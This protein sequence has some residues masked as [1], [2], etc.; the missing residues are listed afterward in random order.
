MTIAARKLTASSITSRVDWMSSDP[1]PARA[2]SGDLLLVGVVV[3]STTA[4]S[5][6][7][8]DTPGLLPPGTPVVQARRDAASCDLSPKGYH[9][10]TLPR[11]RC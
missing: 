11:Q 10:G 4:S 1:R 5:V 7:V 3:G 8:F 2:L 6:V 9:L